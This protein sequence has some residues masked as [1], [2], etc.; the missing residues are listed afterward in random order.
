MKKFDLEDEQTGDVV[1]IIINNDNC[2]KKEATQYYEY[3]KNLKTVH[4]LP[5]E[6]VEIS[7]NKENDEVLLNISYSQPTGF[8]RI[9]R[10]TGY[11]SGSL[12][13]WNDSKRKEEKDRVK[14]I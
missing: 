13:T 5:I 7:F 2:S 4:G 14:H 6:K 3:A 9:R 12:D 10:I 1:E 11:L 8:E